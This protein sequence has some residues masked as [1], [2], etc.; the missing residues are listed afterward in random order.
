MLLEE[1]G[2]GD[3]LVDELNVTE[4]EVLALLLEEGVSVLVGVYE[5]LAEEEPVMDSVAL[6]GVADAV[7][8]FDPE[9]EGVIELEGVCEPVWLLL[10]VIEGVILVV[11]EDDGVGEGLGVKVL[12]SDLLRVAVIELLGVCELVI[13]LLALDD[14]VTEAVL[15]LLVLDDGVTDPVL[16]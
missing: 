9:T 8:E 2:V 16:V 15:V 13:V 4:L 14:G 7:K 6:E 11:L 5:A 12:L 10:R 3:G 1:L